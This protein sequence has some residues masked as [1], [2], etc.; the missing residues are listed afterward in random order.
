MRTVRSPVT[1]THAE[2]DWVQA[3]TDTGLTGAMLTILAIVAFGIALL[4]PRLGWS[5]MTS[6]HLSVAGA[7]AL[8][9]ALLA[10]IG[11]YTMPVL[12]LLLYLTTALVLAVARR[13]MDSSAVA[14]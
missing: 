12:A 4:R 2:S 8:T 11:N 3:A 6:H 10:A 13:R 7:A 1:Y 9:G 5:Q 14:P